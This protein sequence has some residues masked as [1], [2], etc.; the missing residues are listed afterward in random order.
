MIRVV[1]DETAD[2]E[3]EVSEEDKEEARVEAV[4]E[5]LAVEGEAM[6]LGGGKLVRGGGSR[7]ESL[8]LQAVT[9]NRDAPHQERGRGQRG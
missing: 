7:S 5:G 2:S 4:E 1:R 3:T 9:K 6:L 8:R